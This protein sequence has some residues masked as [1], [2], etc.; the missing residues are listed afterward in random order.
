MCMIREMM[1]QKK[2]YIQINV[3]YK[4]LISFCLVY[5]WLFDAFENFFIWWK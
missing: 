3:M 4:I 5:K 2:L 1:I